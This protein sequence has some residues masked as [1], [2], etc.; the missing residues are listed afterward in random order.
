MG[1][2]L[3]HGPS[4]RGPAAAENRGQM[5][6][7]KDGRE[8]SAYIQQLIKHDS[9]AFIKAHYAVN[10]L[11]PKLAK[12]IGVK[13][14]GFE[15]SKTMARGMALYTGVCVMCQKA[16]SVRGEEYCP[17]CIA[18]LDQFSESIKDALRDH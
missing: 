8:I 15:L 11:I 1:A 18:D 12:I 13:E 3:D 17:R 14:F 4:R 10:V 7:E 5:M 16:D 2:R 6:T 9:P